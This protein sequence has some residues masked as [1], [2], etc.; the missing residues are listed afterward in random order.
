MP[1]VIFHPALGLDEQAAARAQDMLRKRIL[2]AFVGRGLLERVEA[3]EMLGYRHSGFSLDT[4]VCIAAQDR[5]G[6]ERLLR[7]CARPLLPCSGCAKRAAS[8][9]TTAPGSTLS[10]ATC[11]ASRL[12]AKPERQ[13]KQPMN[14]T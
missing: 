10:L 1:R 3:R 8:W 9:C 11:R 12:Q 5:T 2:R 4:S 14:C 13:A 6:L 7:Y